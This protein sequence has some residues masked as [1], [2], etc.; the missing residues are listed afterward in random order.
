MPSDETLSGEIQRVTFPA[1][2]FYPA[3]RNEQLSIESVLSSNLRGDATVEFAIENQ[4]DA[5][6]PVTQIALQMRQRKVCFDADPGPTRQFWMLYGGPVEVR[7]PVYDYARLFHPTESAGVATLDVE[8]ANP[9]FVPP[10]AQ[11]AQRSYTDRHPELLWIV[12]LLVVA[13]LGTIAIRSAK[14]AGQS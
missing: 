3:I 8:T 9:L 1:S 10:V 2:G 12:L 7:A 6:L 5:P 4:D 13:A 14:G 11:T